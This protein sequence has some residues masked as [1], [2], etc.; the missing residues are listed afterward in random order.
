MTDIWRVKTTWAYAGRKGE[1]DD[2]VEASDAIEALRRVW[3]EIDAED[4]RTVE[5]EWLGPSIAIL[6]GV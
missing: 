4:L 5:V 2:L 6:K 3:Q 1:T